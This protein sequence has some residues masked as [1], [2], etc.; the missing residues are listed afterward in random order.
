MEW[1]GSGHGH[2]R[3]VGRI[4]VMA[5]MFCI[6]GDAEIALSSADVKGNMASHY[7]FLQVNL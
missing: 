1:D 3:A 2:A 7:S 4:L 6:L 5:E